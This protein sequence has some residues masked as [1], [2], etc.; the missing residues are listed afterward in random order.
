LPSPCCLIA[1]PSWAASAACSATVEANDAMQFNTK[2][3][4]VPK[5]CK[6]FTVTLKHT[7]KL[8]KA[9]MGHDWVLSRAGDEAG[10][11]ADGAKAGIENDYLKPGDNR[12]IAH[13]KIIGGG[14]TAS[15]AFKVSALKAGE[16]YAFFCSFPGHAALMK[17]TLTLK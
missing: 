6:Q 8:P 7:G 3:I 16:A 15:T 14:E 5:T 11:D 10:I 12:V 2:N 1:A 13:T 17:G 9:A 4:E